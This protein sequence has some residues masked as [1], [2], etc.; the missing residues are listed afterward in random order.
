M[1]NFTI[2]FILF[3]LGLFGVISMLTVT[4]PLDKL[5]K[6]VVDKIPAE[7][8]KWIILINPAILL[9][10]AIVIGTILFRKVN[11][12]ILFVSTFFDKE[13]THL[14]LL[15]QLKFGVLGGI[16]VG[17]ITSLLSF[18]IL[19]LIPNEVA[20]LGEEIKLTAIARL[21]YGGITEE[22]L[23]R[24]G[25]MTLVVWIVYKITKSLQSKTYWTGILVASLGFAL[26]HFPI[27]YNSIENPSLFIL[28]YV[29][30][31][32]SIAGIAFGWLYWKKGLEAAFFGHAMSH[33]AMMVFENYIF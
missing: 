13:K 19:K 3:I 25:F 1:K 15:N 28:S 26:G 18:A 4:I 31:G 14:T 6:E 27:V 5:P 22:I 32:N 16:I 8:L 20:Q 11:F 23:M 24:F 7:T 33:I 30:I 17:I 9:L 12:K 2:G 21:L 10:L 29:L